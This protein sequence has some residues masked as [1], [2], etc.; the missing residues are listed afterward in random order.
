MEN[1]SNKVSFHERITAV[2][3]A[4]SEQ[5]LFNIIAIEAPTFRRFYRQ[6]RKAEPLKCDKMKEAAKLRGVSVT[7]LYRLIIRGKHPKV[8]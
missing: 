6:G 2:R 8:I 4:K 1:Y 3:N 5:E 7:H